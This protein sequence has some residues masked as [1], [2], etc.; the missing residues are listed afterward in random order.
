M[1]AMLAAA[2]L[3]LVRWY[4][5]FAGESICAPDWIVSVLLMCGMVAWW[6]N[7]FWFSLRLPQWK[8]YLK[9]QTKGLVALKPMF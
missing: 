8:G 7:V 4:G 9:M 5:V 2:V 3:L 1:K 6:Q